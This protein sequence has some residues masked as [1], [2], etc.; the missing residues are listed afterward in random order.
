[1]EHTLTSLRREN[2]VDIASGWRRNWVGD[3]LGRRGSDMR[4]A[5][6]GDERAGRQKG[7]YFVGRHL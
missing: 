3:G 5:G 2:I 6:V 7:N 1:M 4:R